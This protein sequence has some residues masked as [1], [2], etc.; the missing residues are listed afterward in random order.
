MKCC[1][2]SRCGSGL[3]AKNIFRLIYD[4]GYI[5]IK[6]EL[7]LYSSYYGAALM[8]NE[9]DDVASKKDIP[10]APYEFQVREQYSSVYPEAMYS[11]SKK[12]K[13]TLK[14]PNLQQE[15]LNFFNNYITGMKAYFTPDNTH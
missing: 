3:I 13:I 6:H 15:L 8:I 4:S 12:G 14:N 11:F 7:E 1:D 5:K 2:K 10:F 9:N